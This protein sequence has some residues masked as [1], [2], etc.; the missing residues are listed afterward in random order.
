MFNA[1]DNL[2]ISESRKQFLISCHETLHNS[3]SIT[4]S[5]SL[6]LYLDS[7][8]LLL[9][10]QE[11]FTERSLEAVSTSNNEEKLLLITVLQ[12]LTSCPTYID[13]FQNEHF[14]S[15]VALLNDAN[16]VLAYSAVRLVVV[17]FKKSVID[18]GLVIY[19]LGSLL[20]CLIKHLY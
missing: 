8:Q 17:C 15:V 20:G 3:G 4:S 2:Q 7:K 16:E 6:S 5:S 18:V 11:L 19:L 9:V 10:M 14:K 1:T 13:F 12:D